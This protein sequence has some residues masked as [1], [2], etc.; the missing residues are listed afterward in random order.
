ME[1]AIAENPGTGPTGRPAIL[2]HYGEIALKHGNRPYFEE[3]LTRNIRTALGLDLPCEIRRLPGRM[4]VYPEN[5]VHSG[6]AIKRLANVFGIENIAPAA[7]VDP[8]IAEI[9]RAALEAAASRTFGSFAIRARR[10]EKGFHLNSKEINE[11]V[12]EAV[13]LKTGARVDLTSPECTIGI[14]VLDRHAF[15]FADR[16]EGPGG[17][18]VGTSGKVACLISGGIDSP[19]A[20][21]RMM[22]RGCL[23]TFVHFHSAPFTGPESRD[24]A[25]EI[26][27]LLMRC[28]PGSALI[29]VP[30][31]EIQKKI[32]TGA[33]EAFRI[34]LYRRF[35]V[36]IACEL[37]KGHGAEALVTGESLAQVASQTL[38]NL[39]AIDAASSLPILR[40]LVGLD[41]KE[42]VD[43]ATRIETFNLSIQPHDDCCSFL[44]P[45]HPATRS[46]RAQL[47]EVERALCVDALVKMGVEGSSERAI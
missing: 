5:G 14:E 16:V 27:E 24:K 11:R 45:R 17:L 12:G 29:F 2:I 33:P 28:Q 8:D 4:V 13:R 10:G 15:I 36:R 46:T 35:M 25:E 37:A 26:V 23:P 38:S 20:A 47:D 7:R 40:P 6:A 1:P 34:L 22:K 39:S 32:I 3:A 31:G 41:K 18:P 43:E 9:T 30:F 44:T 42:I 21:W 19:V